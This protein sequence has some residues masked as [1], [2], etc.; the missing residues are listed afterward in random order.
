MIIT[1]RPKKKV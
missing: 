1:Q